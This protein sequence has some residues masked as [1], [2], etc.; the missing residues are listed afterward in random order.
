MK[1]GRW[2]VTWRSVPLVIHD[3]GLVRAIVD[4]AT[5]LGDVS[6]WVSTATIRDVLKEHP[7]PVNCIRVEVSKCPSPKL[8]RKW[9]KLIRAKKRGR[10]L[11]ELVLVNKNQPQTRPSI[12]VSSQADPAALGNSHW[13][14][15]P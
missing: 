7:G 3:T 8:V 14:S 13:A 12:C 2:E 6:T 1:K 4:L 5:D 15:L 10:P 9:M 11:Q